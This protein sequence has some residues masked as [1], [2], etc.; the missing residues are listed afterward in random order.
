MG[1]DIDRDVGGPPNYLRTNQTIVFH[2]AIKFPA[3]LQQHVAQKCQ[4]AT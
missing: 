3:N 1:Q 2:V 4:T